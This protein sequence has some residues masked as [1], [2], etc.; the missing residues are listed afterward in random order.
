M[1]DNEKIAEVKGLLGDEVHT[2]NE[3]LISAGEEGLDGATIIRWLTA[4]NNDPAVAV[5]RLIGHAEWRKQLTSDNNE[6]EVLS[7]QDT[8]N[9]WKLYYKGEQYHSKSPKP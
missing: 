4:S 1:I 6:H 3:T 9:A 8:S 5:S 2:V 7:E